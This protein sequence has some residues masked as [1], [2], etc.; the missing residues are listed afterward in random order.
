MRKSGAKLQL[1]ILSANKSKIGIGR[2]SLTKF[3]KCTTLLKIGTIYGAK[4]KRRDKKSKLGSVV[5]RT[6]IGDKVLTKR[7]IFR[8]QTLPKS[9]KKSLD[10]RRSLTGKTSLRRSATWKQGE[11]RSGKGGRWRWVAR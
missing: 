11:G 3:T 10:R 8:S 2:I 4:R 7:R 6:F 1:L 5:I 9:R